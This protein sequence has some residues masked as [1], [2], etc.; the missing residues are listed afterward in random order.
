MIYATIS[1][2]LCFLQIMRI[3][4]SVCL[5][6]LEISFLAPFALLFYHTHTIN[7]PMSSLLIVAKR[8]NAFVSKYIQANISLVKLEFSHSNC[9]LFQWH[10]L[11]FAPPPGSLA[12][13]RVKKY[14]EKQQKCQVAWRFQ[15]SS[16]FALRF[17][18]YAKSCQLQSLSI[19]WKFSI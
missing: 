6:S 14:L 11:Y 9:S 7:F 1:L 18:V 12:V 19:K 8:T 2:S 15:F 5:P 4:R 16:K 13:R 10:L 17:E 3:L